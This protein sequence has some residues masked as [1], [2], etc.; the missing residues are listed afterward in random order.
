[1]KHKLR[2]VLVAGP[3]S[4]AGFLPPND[5][6][7]LIAAPAGQERVA[8]RLLAACGR[9]K[10]AVFAAGPSG[11]EKNVH[12][13]MFVSDVD[14]DPKFLTSEVTLGPGVGAEKGQRSSQP[15]H[16]KK[17]TDAGAKVAPAVVQYRADAVRALFLDGEILVGSLATLFPSIEWTTDP[18]GMVVQYTN[19]HPTPPPAVVTPWRMAPMRQ[20]GRARSPIVVKVQ[21]LPNPPHGIRGPMLKSKLDALMVRG[22]PLRDGDIVIDGYGRKWF[23]VDGDLWSH[24]R[25]AVLRTSVIREGE[26]LRPLRVQN[27]LKNHGRHDD[28]PALEVGDPLEV[29]LLGGPEETVV[30]Y[31]VLTSLDPVLMTWTARVTTSSN[32]VQDAEATC[33]GFQQAINAVDCVRKGGVWDKPCYL[34]TECPYFDPLSNRGGC[35]QG[36]CEMPLGVGNKSFRTPDP[37]TPPMCRGG[38]GPSPFCSQEIRD[39]PFHPGALK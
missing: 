29:T 2:A 7:V 15:Q 32:L 31:G 17:N 21:T 1:M 12:A 27:M 16:E 23:V 3:A 5:A 18:G 30:V 24:R 35:N 39:A 19:Q 6:P 36:M 28:L 20:F 34:D 22:V 33:F 37:E 9:S 4:I 8:H 10:V 11:T 14:D 25:V 26:T 13:T 38:A